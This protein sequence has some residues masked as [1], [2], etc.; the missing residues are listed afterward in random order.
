MLIEKSPSN[1][2]TLESMRR[3][4][5][6]FPR[7]R[8]IHLLRHPRTQAESTLAHRE[9]KRENGVPV[10]AFWRDPPEGWYANH[11]LICR[12]LRSIDQDL[13]VRVR[14]EDLLADPER[15]VR[16]ILD[17][18][19]LRTDPEAIEAVMHPERSPY[20]CIGPRGALF[21]NNGNF[22]KNPRFSPAPLKRVNLDDPL[23]WRPSR[24]FPPYVKRLARHFGYQ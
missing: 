16:S 8:F 12:F 23:G 1:T 10:A 7:A 13:S 22:L 5:R 15:V 3:A 4:H 9:R 20:A 21:G 14:G 18:L 11:S 19:G 2:R 17:W 6:M 24:G